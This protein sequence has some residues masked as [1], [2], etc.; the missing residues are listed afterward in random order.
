MVTRIWKYA[1][2]ATACLLI[3]QVLWYLL[4]LR[5]YQVEWFVTC[6]GVLFLTIGFLLAKELKATRK[7]FVAPVDAETLKL[8]YDLSPSEAEILEMICAGMANHEIADRRNVSVNTV[9]THISHLYT[10]LGVNSRT[11]A[12]AM[13]KSK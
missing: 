9:K 1:F 4:L 13:V 8:R 10:K 3:I 5:S 11:Q 2:F 12:V 7:T 6:I